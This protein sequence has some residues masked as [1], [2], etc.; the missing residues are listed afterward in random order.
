M[1]EEKLTNDFSARTAQDYTAF[2]DH[3]NGMVIVSWF[4]P[5]G[6]DWLTDDERNKLADVFGPMS[7]ELEEQQAKNGKLS[8]EEQLAQ[9][10]L[11][12]DRLQAEGNKVLPK[13]KHAT[14]A[15]SVATMRGTLK[16][17]VESNSQ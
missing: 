7:R 2:D 1:L 5:S 6:H 16:Q 3:R 13:A 12:I 4:S 14:L 15:K 11:Y 9:S 17:M 10:N 8:K